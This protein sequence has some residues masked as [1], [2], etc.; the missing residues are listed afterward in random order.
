MSTQKKAMGTQHNFSQSKQGCCI[1]DTLVDTKR[2]LCN[3]R[4]LC[5]DT[6]FLI[7]KSYVEYTK[8]FS[9][10]LTQSFLCKLVSWVLFWLNKLFFKTRMCYIDIIYISN[11]YKLNACHLHLL[12]RAI[13][14]T[15][16]LQ[17]KTTLP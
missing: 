11:S 15:P 16:S 3:Q 10:V 12:I 9:C 8:V 2:S 13:V 4:N 6:K 7:G 17:V 1:W 5:I 14:S